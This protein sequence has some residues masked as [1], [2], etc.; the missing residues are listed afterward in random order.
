MVLCGAKLRVAR[1]YGC[2]APGKDTQ[3]FRIFVAANHREMSQEIDAAARRK[4]LVKGYALGAVA[5]ATYGLN[6]LFALP[7]YADGMNPDS[8]LFFRY[9][10]AAVALSVMLL[11]RRGP[12]FGV[13]WRKLPA[14][15]FLGIMMA[16][17][18]ITLYSA[19]TY[20]AAGVA[21]TLLFVYPVMTA[22]LMALFFHERAGWATFVSIGLALLGIGLLYKGED[23]ATLSLLGTGLVFVSALTYAIYLIFIDHAGLEGMPTL[24]VTTYVL[25]AGVL[26]F[27]CRLWWQGQVL[28]PARWWLWGCV[29]ASGIVPTAI[30]LL[31]TTAAIPIIGSTP[32][33]ILGA[34][35]PVTAVV[36]GA[37]VFSEPLTGRLCVGILLIIVAVTLVIAGGSLPRVVNRMRRM[38]PRK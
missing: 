23:G 2:A 30:S 27:A 18:S 8:V 36:V 29:L 19:Y 13:P 11:V 34:L 22:V 3:N 1:R 28:V 37:L 35:E 33:A 32:T 16:L 7:L 17:S 25:V 20:M 26:F 12:D 14:L 6:P 5:A 38:F 24:K 4:K 31:C 21:S 10:V 15:G 9:L